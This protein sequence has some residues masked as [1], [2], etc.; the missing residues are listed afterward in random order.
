MVVM[1]VRKEMSTNVPMVAKKKLKLEKMFL[2]A[3]A[4]DRLVRIT[5]YSNINLFHNI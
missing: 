4:V 3:S 5:T 1:L 2:N